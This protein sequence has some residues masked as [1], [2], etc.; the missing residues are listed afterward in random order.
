MSKRA[1]VQ[2]HCMDKR[3]DEYEKVSVMIDAGASDTVAS[4]G[5]IQ[6]DPLETTMV[7]GKTYSSAA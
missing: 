3:E 6:P 1:D 7:S 5:K 4:M 2:T